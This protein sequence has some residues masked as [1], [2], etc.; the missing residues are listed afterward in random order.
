MLDSIVWAVGLP[1]TQLMDACLAAAHKELGRNRE[2]VIAACRSIPF[3]A[4]MRQAISDSPLPF[5]GMQAVCLIPMLSGTP[6]DLFLK[7]LS[8]QCCI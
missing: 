3:A 5:L 6:P 7:T 4:S 8:I 2:D 1:W